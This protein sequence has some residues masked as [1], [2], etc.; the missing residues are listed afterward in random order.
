MVPSVLESTRSG[1]SARLR[2]GRE[3]LGVDVT[4]RHKEFVEAEGGRTHG[5]VADQGD[6]P[7][8]KEPTN[9]LTEEGS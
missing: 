4:G 6:G 9:I 2:R 5:N 7:Y 3:G 8:K 1:R